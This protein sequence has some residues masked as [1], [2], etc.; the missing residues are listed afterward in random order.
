MKKFALLLSLFLCLPLAQG[1]GQVTGSVVDEQFNIN[2]NVL[3]ALTITYQSDLEFGDVF[4]NTTKSVTPAGVPSYPATGATPSAAKMRI[5]GMPDREVIVW[6]E[7]HEV[8]TFGTN[9]LD[10]DYTA[11]DAVFVAGTGLPG[12]GVAW[13]PT[14]S[15]TTSQDLDVSG[16]ATIYLGG[17]IAP[18]SGTHAAGAYTAAAS[19]YVGYTGN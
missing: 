4:Q 2:A 8:I 14:A 10:V 3:T 11:A 12:T 5:D 19:L 7:D 18:V 17:T 9:N 6:F 1:F 15:A 16:V 13:N